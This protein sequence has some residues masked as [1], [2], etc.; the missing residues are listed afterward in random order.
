MTDNF[1]YNK[2]LKYKRKYLLLKGGNHDDRTLYINFEYPKI[3]SNTIRCKSRE[4]DEK[5]DEFYESSQ[6]INIYSSNLDSDIKLKNKTIDWCIDN[7]ES[8]MKNNVKDIYH[9]N[10]SFNPKDIIDYLNLAVQYNYKVII[11]LP[12][13]TKKT[14]E[15]II[16]INKMNIIILELKTD[17]NDPSMW[18][19]KINKTFI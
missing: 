16:N 6:Y 2:A 1:Y 9:T 19:D 4:V 18:I 14:G 8:N 7:I 17:V 13:I 12:D 5:K 3:D 15:E 11:S 10:Y